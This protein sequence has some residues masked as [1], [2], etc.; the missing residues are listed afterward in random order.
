MNT[1]DSSSL[2]LNTHSLLYAY[3]A[4]FIS[5]RITICWSFIVLPCEGFT[6]IHCSLALLPCE[7][8][9]AIHCSLTVLHVKAPSPCTLHSLAVSPC[10]D[11]MAGSPSV[12]SIAILYLLAVRGVHCYLLVACSLT[13]LSHCLH[14]ETPRGENSVGRLTCASSKAGLICHSCC[15]QTFA[16]PQ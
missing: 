16:L 10:E 15:P 5:I 7:G 14:K 11:S 4:L 2:L 13:V 12:Y 1:S 9:I 8:F 3:A 6:A